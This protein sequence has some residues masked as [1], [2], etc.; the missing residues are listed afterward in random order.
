MAHYAYIDES[1][2][3]VD[4]IVGKDENE[5]IDGLDTETYYAQDTAY[6]VKRT[7]YNGKIRY[8][9]AGIGYTYDPIADAFIAPKPYPS[10]V[11]NSKKQWEPPIAYPTDGK[12]YGWNEETGDWHEA[13]AL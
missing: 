2:K 8:N 12:L 4:V 9:Y 5:L 13:E 3:V 6:T 7:S 11:L 1:S 10:W